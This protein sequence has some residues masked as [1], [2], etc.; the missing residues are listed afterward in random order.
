MNADE[1]SVPD[2]DKVLEEGAALQRQLPWLNLVVVGGAAAAIH[3]E[4]RYSTDTDHVSL[5]VSNNFDR[6]KAELE[7]WEG[8]KTNRVRRPFVI[9]GERHEVE[10]GVRQQRRSEPL[11]VERK[12]GLWVPTP[13]EAL[14]IKAFLCTDRQA[15][16]DYLDVAALAD[17]L[18]E[19]ETEAALARLNLLYE[20]EGNQSCV[21][22]FAEVSQQDPVDL[23]DV[24][25]DTYRGIQ[26]PYDDW[27]YVKERVAKIG[28]RLLEMEMRGELPAP[29]QEDRTQSNESRDSEGRTP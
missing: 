3:A 9:L 16:R 13:A 27:Q 18:G 10:L 23:E 29:P 12:R 19:E 1:S 7:T 8:W 15:T 24:E 22:R 5:D 2:F 14:R 26:P 11:E 25:L 21:S 17:H 28:A 4:H 20:G 6:L